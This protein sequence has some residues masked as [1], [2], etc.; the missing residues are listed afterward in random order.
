[1][2]ESPGMNGQW[3]G[4]YDG[5]T[6]GAIVVNVDEQGSNFIG[7]AYLVDN[8]PAVPALVAFFTIANKERKF[9]FR[10][11]SIQWFDPKAFNSFGG[12]IGLEAIAARYPKDTAFSTFADVD[13]ACDKDNLTLSW[14]TDIG[15]AGTCVLPRTVADKPSELKTQNLN[16]GDYRGYISTLTPRRHL[17][18]GQSAPFRLRTSFHRSGRAHLNRIPKRRHSN[19]AQASQRAHETSLQPPNS[20]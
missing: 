1:M 15:T 6:N 4:T 20:G 18:R 10:T 19:A 16:W 13:G 11:D 7:E 14:K 9:H 17:F 2:S 8:N 3:V 5:S 12:F